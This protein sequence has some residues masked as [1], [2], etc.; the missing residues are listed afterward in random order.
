MAS[1]YWWGKQWVAQ[2]YRPDGSKAKRGTG[3]GKGKRRE[4]ERA[5]AVMEEKDRK[6]QNDSGRKYEEIIARAG[7][8]AKAGRMS[9]D[10]AAEYLLEIRRVADPAFKVVSLQEHLESWCAEKCA[11]VEPSTAAGYNDM[12]R[13]FSASLDTSVMKAPLTDLT[14]AQ[15]EKALSKMKNRGLKAA[16]VNLDLRALRQALKQAQEDGLVAKNVAATVKPLHETDSIERAPFSAQE[17]RQLIDHEKTSEEWRGMILF[18]GHTG[19][20]L[21]DVAQLSRAHIDGTDLVIRPQ[22]TKRTK[23]ILRIPLT[24]PLL[25]WMNGRKG[26]FFPTLSKKSSSTLSMQFSALMRH[27][28]IPSK[29]M[30][31]GGIEASRSYHSLRHSFASW[32]AEGDVHADVRMSLTGHSDEG[33]HSRYSH[34]DQSLDRAIAVLPDLTPQLAKEGKK[35]LRSEAREDS[36]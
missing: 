8:T 9:P 13:R 27:A 26:Q 15:I 6:E 33:I 23:K 19:L 14:R 22:K 10:R 12:K 21:R 25:T 7:A 20:R 28:G 24:P 17:V 35:P 5:A 18:G 16:T 2:W 31:P 29:I 11:R 4:A 34:R 3:I 32:L 36:A 1:V 30:L